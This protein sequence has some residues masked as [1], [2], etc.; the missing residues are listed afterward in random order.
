MWNL[1]K[2]KDPYIG[3]IY[4]GYFRGLSTSGLCS[5]KTICGP[6]QCVERNF[7][8]IKESDITDRINRKIRIHG[9]WFKEDQM[10]KYDDIYEPLRNDILKKYGKDNNDM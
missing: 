7:Y 9:E 5:L 1:F 6:G 2:K 10:F 4:A 3:E 8:L